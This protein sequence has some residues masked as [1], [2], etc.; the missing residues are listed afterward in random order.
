MFVSHTFIPLA[1]KYNKDVNSLVGRIPGAERELTLRAGNVFLVLFWSLF[2]FQFFC[3]SSFFSPKFVVL[4]Y[5][6]LTF[7]ILFT[8]LF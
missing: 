5:Y 4:G 2:L 3:S 1:C 6:V 8:G 7:F